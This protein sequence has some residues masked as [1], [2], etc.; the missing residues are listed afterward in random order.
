ML[1]QTK[2]EILA[3][4]RH[5][6]LHV[7]LSSFP[8]RV[9]AAK[10]KKKKRENKRRLR[11]SGAKGELREGGLVVMVGAMVGASAA[12]TVTKPALLS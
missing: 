9:S 10:K 12:C 2:N 3:L 6:L 8:P 5:I 4:S 7:F 11:S 1:Q